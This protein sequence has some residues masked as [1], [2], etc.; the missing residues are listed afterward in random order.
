[1]AKKEFTPAELFD[2][3]RASLH[4]LGGLGVVA[5]IVLMLAELIT[6]DPGVILLFLAAFVYTLGDVLKAVTESLK[7]KKQ[8]DA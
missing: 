6:A 2:K 5:A 7:A 4:V 3:A 1:M 8:E